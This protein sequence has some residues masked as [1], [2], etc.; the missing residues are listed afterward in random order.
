MNIPSA[1]NAPLGVT[2]TSL[3][4][5]LSILWSLG[6]VSMKV[7]VLGISPVMSSGLRSMGAAILVFA[8]MLILS[9]PVFIRDRTFWPGLLAGLLFAVEFSCIY[10][11]LTHTT[12]ARVTVFVF[13]A[14]FFV[15]LGGHFFIEG[16][17]LNKG[18]M[19]GLSCAF[20]GVFVAFAEGFFATDGQATLLG[21]SLALFAGALW[22]LTTLTVKMTR[23]ATISSER[24]L[25]YQHVVAG[26]LLIPFS[27]LIGE[28]GIFNP[29]LLVMGLLAFQTIIIAAISYLA[30]F[31]MLTKYSA[32]RLSA[33][34]LVSP[35]AGVF[36]GWLLL[37]ETVSP[38]LGLAVFLVAYGIWRVNREPATTVSASAANTQ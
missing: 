27:I 32:T 29:T 17:R 31:H 23:L 30:W 35:V 20:A 34:T 5:F 22:G 14:P 2:A 16:E 11:A 33:F 28:K 36:F 12:A 1:S 19:L 15:S 25:L 4:L 9:K 7:T 38:Q 21:D 24:V 8:W 18:K 6:S 13:T 10:L 37:N 26:V 3:I